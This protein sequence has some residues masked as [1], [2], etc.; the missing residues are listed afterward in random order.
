MN[1]VLGE[2]TWGVHAFRHQ[3]AMDATYLGLSVIIWIVLLLVSALIVGLVVLTMRKRRKKTLV[4]KLQRQR[5]AMEG[6]TSDLFTERGADEIRSAVDQPGKP[7]TKISDGAVAYTETGEM[8]VF[9]SSDATEDGDVVA[10]AVDQISSKGGV[11]GV[12]T[13]SPTY[14]IEMIIALHITGVAMFAVDT[15]G[16][17]VNGRELDQDLLIILERL[18]EEA[19][20]LGGEM[21]K[22][23]Y[24][25]RT[26]SLTW[27]EG[28][29]MAAV[30][31]GEP[32]ERLDREL[33]WAVG[34]I[35]EDFA[36]DIWAWGDDTD[37]SASR[38]LTHRLRKV[39]NLTVGVKPGLLDSKSKG[40]GLRV[41]STISWRHSLAEYTLGI[42][43]NGP[44]PVHDLELL[45]TLNKDGVVEVATV[46]GI[47]VDK[48]MRFRLDDVDQGKKVVATFAFRVPEPMDVRVDCTLIY[49]RGVTNAQKLKLPG[50][51]IE[52]E[53][54]EPVG[55]GEM[56]EPERALELAT[57][58]ATFRDRCA[59]YAPRGS[60]VESL[61]N[62]MIE[63]LSGRMDP[64]VELE[65]DDGSQQEAWFH[66]DVI[67]GGTVI[68]SITAVPKKGIIDMFATSTEAGVVPST[69]VT[70]RQVAN[71]A[72]GQALPEV[73]D[74]ELRTT[75]PRMGV[76]LFQSWGFFDE[77]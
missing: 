49:R 24:K 25:D 33:R 67:G 22:A 35:T 12:P 7:T 9:Q 64:V 73:L 16:K 58:H 75:V 15:K 32:D 50:R 48:D 28:L 69:M 29:H 43:N 4:D 5:Q 39:F 37:R 66:G 19:R 51:W 54:R 74:P 41:S 23:P 14:R 46:Y 77:D 65:D 8:L 11:G 34:D 31:D 26:I 10:S 62:A 60:S 71:A 53:R 42:I 21:V 38:E 30:I 40:G 55:R 63:D 27:G 45:P 13:W 57:Q 52:L 72:A 61:L 68:V 17:V 3:L 36:D 47:N 76:L 18:L 70:L 2:G 56:V 1:D 6:A 44:G 59:V 20:W